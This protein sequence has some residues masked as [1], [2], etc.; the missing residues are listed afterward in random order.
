V[1]T[2]PTSPGR[3]LAVASVAMFLISLDATIGFA[4]YPTLQVRFR[5]TSPATLAWVLTAYTIVYA[6]LL[7]PAGRLADL[8]GRKRLFLWGLV[9]FA[10]SSAAR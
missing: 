3:V 1:S 7:V 4:L 2:R 10:G 8:K 5:D 6:A 9:L